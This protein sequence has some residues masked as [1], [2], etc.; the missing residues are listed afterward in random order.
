MSLTA[1][2]LGTFFQTPDG[3]TVLGGSGGS[4]LD[5]QSLIKVLTDA[6]GTAIVQSQDQITVNDKQA[7]ALSTFQQLLGTF[8][9][10][11]DILR[12]PPGVGNDV[13]NVFKY[14]TATVSSNTAIAGSNYL[15]VTTT[16]GAA[17]QSYSVNDIEQLATAGQ[18]TTG[19]FTI[20]DANTTIVSASPIGGTA[21]QFGPGTITFNGQAITLTEGD[22]L[23]TVASK[24]NAVSETTGVSATVIQGLAGQFQMI[25]T[26]TETGAANSFDL[27]AATDPSG[28]LT[29]IGLT[30]TGTGLNAKFKINGIQVERST[31][32]IND[33]VDGLTFELL[34][35]TPD[36]D[37]ILTVGVQ[38]D[39][40]LAQNAITNFAVAYNALKTFYAQQTQLKGDGTYADTAVLANN[41]AFRAIMAETMA[42]VNSKVAGIAGSNPSSLSDIGVTFAKQPATSTTPEVSNILT[43]DD[44]KLT[45]MLS[46]NFNG[47][48]NLFGFHLTSDNPNLAVFSRTNALAATSFTLNINPGTNTFTAT[49]NPGT[50]PVTVNL[51]A[52]AFSATPGYSLTG[53]EGTALAGLVLIYGSNSSATINVTTTQGIGDKAYNTSQNALKEN[54]GTLAIEQK[55]LKDSDTRLNEDI[56]RVTLQ[57]NQYRNEL[58]M[59]FGALEQAISRVNTLLQSLNANQNAALANSGN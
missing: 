42:E 33:V 23:N 25:F 9:S 44:N 47:V 2:T 24:F 55:T 6:K 35:A 52:H 8:Q 19:I 36:E 31:N 26:A 14:T 46:T 5:V 49:Y 16:P 4:G 11:V 51:T 10:T 43:I 3:K 13:N 27:S 56:A 21:N 15:S 12:N 38:P 20:A 58:L 37:T 40:A 50:G 17:L 45:S 1:V 41:Q 30:G 28:V 59:K 7:T 34:Q 57:I 22:S 39:R 54:T 32:S 29:D 48:S 18:Q 53:Q